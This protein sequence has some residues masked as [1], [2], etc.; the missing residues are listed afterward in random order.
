MYAA[1]WRSLPGPAWVR[2]LVCVVLVV[3]VVAVLFE[4]GF[5]ALAEVLP[6]NA[7]TVG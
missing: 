4:W 1:L 2:A 3:A 6:F 5:P 7:N